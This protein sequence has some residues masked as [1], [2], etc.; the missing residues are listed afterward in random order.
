MAV[1]ISIQP[2]VAN[3]D[4]NTIVY[5][6][7]IRRSEKAAKML[8]TQAP[9]GGIEPMLFVVDFN[10]CGKDEIRKIYYTYI[11]TPA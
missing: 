10:F 4:A 7:P 6:R 11:D 9:H 5:F 1:A 3:G 2:M 8:P